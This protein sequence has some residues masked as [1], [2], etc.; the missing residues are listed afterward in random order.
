MTYKQTIEYLFSQLPMYQ[1]QGQLAFKKDLTNIIALCEHNNNPQNNFVSIH[2]AGTNGKG[3]V[4]HILASILQ[5]A[6]YKTG[7]YTSPHLKDFRER[8][9]INGKMISE[10]SVINYVKNNSLIFEDTK[11]SFFEMTVAMA[12]NHFAK[13]K[14][15]IAI[16]ETGLG[17][18]LDSTNI[19]KPI[20]S[21][22]TNISIDHTQFLGNTIKEIALEKA[23]IIKEKTPI[24]I[25]ETNNISSK[26][27]IEIANKKNAPIYFADSEYKIHYSLLNTDYKQVFNIEKNNNLFYENLITDLIGLYQ[28]KNVITS[29]KAIDIIS[30]K[31]NISQA[32][33]YDGFLNVQKH[34]G[35]AGRWNVLNFNPLTVADT[36]HNV[37]G[38]NEVVSQIKNTAY[39]KLHF[40]Y[41]TVNDKNI[42]EILEL[43]PKNAN[44]YF[45]QAKIPRALNAKKLK[46]KAYKIGLTGNSYSNTKDAF[47]EAKK[48][49]HKED[50]ILIG[51]STFIVAEL[52]DWN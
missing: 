47:N 5:T 14:V 20:L 40:I 45:T 30:K 25:G 22:I 10:N 50:L 41:G 34:T 4:S 11:P 39:K 36:G 1:R 9:R 3:S 42:N 44:Y 33:I 23:G 13:N 16:I 37:A 26:V 46:D 2:I 49:A 21:V 8:I 18:R 43:L 7:L 19:I 52:I 6:G 12:F 48:N 27:F 35:L 15:D 51:G 29:L 24:V 32:N 28:K 38:I 31:F 17:G